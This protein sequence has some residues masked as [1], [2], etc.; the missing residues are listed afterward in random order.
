MKTM[1]ERD[2]EI[3]AA[4]AAYEA[5]KSPAFLPLVD[6]QAIIRGIEAAAARAVERA[7]PDRFTGAP[8]GAFAKH[9]AVCQEFEDSLIEP[10]KAAIDKAHEAFGFLVAMSPKSGPTDEQMASAL[11][12]IFLSQAI[13]R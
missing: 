7:L 8:V 4:V 3:V 1:A 2:R 5:G 12:A 9:V 10:K 11:R 6:G 13:G